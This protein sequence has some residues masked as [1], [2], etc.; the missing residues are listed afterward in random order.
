MPV[1]EN[2]PAGEG[3][4]PSGPLRLGLFDIMQVDP[5]GEEAIADMYAKRLDTLALADT[6][7]YTVAFAAERHFMPSYACPSATAWIAAG[8][9]SGSGSLRRQVP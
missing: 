1:S 8:W 7:G 4:V 6:L 2:R 9:S 5:G 3:L